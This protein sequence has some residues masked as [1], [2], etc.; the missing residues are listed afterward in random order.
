[1]K[2]IY[3]T[4]ALAAWALGIGL[5]LA[6]CNSN[7]S[8]SSEAQNNLMKDSA[9]ASNDDFQWQSEQFADLRILRYQVPGWEKLPL[10]QKK[11]AYYLT[12]AGLEGRD[13]Y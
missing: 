6:G 7:K 5:L 10:R 3:P 4:T 8:E 12:Q 13:I 9:Q 11:L 1:M 2:C